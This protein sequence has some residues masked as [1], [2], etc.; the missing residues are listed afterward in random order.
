M[1]KVCTYCGHPESQHETTYI[2]GHAWYRCKE[3][4]AAGNEKK[5][6]PQ[7]PFHIALF[8]EKEPDAKA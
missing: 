6:W 5:G 2:D 7:G 4:F 1:P 3:C 8:V